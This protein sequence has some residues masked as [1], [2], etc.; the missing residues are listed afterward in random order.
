MT[1]TSATAPGPPGNRWLGHLPQFMRDKVGFLSRCAQQYGPVVSLKLGKQTLLLSGPDD[2]KHILITNARNYVKTPRLHSQQ[3]RSN[4]GDNLLTSS[5]TAH[6][7]RRRLLT[8]LYHNILN[9]QIAGTIV[10]ETRRVGSGWKSGD[11]VDMSSAMHDLTQTVMI[12]MLIGD[13]RETNIA[14][15]AKAIT[16]R[17]NHYSHLLGS[18]LPFP[19]YLP[20]RTR[21]GYANAMRRIDETIRLAIQRRRAHPQ[22]ASDVI[23]G[24]VHARNIDGAVLD[25][26]QIR[27]EAITFIDVGYETISA[28]L[29]WSWH[30]LA[31]NPEAQETLRSESRQILQGRDPQASDVRRLEYT[32]MV[33]SE[34]LRIY[35]PSW[36]FVRIPLEDDVLPSGAKVTPATKLYLCPYAAHRNPALWP[37][38]ER[39]DPQRF[40]EAAT[41]SRPRLAYFPFGAGPHQC[42]GEQFAK[43]Q[44]A[45]VLAMLSQM[46][47]FSPVSD[48]PSEL[49]TGVVLKPRKPIR[50][51]ID[52]ASA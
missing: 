23:S 46:F 7:K 47:R 34:A 39:F 21:W 45:I 41:E 18:V 40:T 19:E 3:G 51:R 32:T 28:A 30:L 43:F 4:L 48:A 12:R 36:M 5:G 16:I 26:D 49:S 10:A 15:L 14:A 17:R 9:E 42:I 1:Q 6:Q 38:P 44:G 50:M 27:E 33:L 52:L 35:P 11:V 13:D 31:R 25:D 20:S 24:Y 2:L 8:P 29:V 22:R 37:D